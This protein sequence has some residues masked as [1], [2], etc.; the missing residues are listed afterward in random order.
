MTA[1]SEPESSSNPIPVPTLASI[2]RN[3]DRDAGTTT[4]TIH[5]ATGSKIEY[6]DNGTTIT[7]RTY[8]YPDTDTAHQTR[9]IAD[10]TRTDIED[11]EQLETLAVEFMSRFDS[12]NTTIGDLERDYTDDVIEAITPAGADPDDNV[13]KV[14]HELDKKIREQQP[15]RNSM[16]AL[17]NTDSNITTK[18][19]FPIG[20]QFYTGSSIIEIVGY[21]N[22]DSDVME[23]Y[24][25]RPVT[26]NGERDRAFHNSARAFHMSFINLN[27]HLIRYGG[28]E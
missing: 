6:Q 20:T 18:Y 22:S 27:K 10:S 28:S 5:I 2:A 17:L 21:Y 19:R 16:E 23:G 9:T 7:Q 11:V 4:I 26:H 24:K 3:A 8:L 25:Y 12:F 15:G 14:D 1:T 13:W